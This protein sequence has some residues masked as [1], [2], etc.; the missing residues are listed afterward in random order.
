MKKILTVFSLT[1]LL[2]CG[3]SYGRNNDLPENSDEAA[4]D[5]LLLHVFFATPKYLK[6]QEQ[7]LKVAEGNSSFLHASPA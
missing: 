3:C 2:L 6:M 4:K 7:F 5:I 1:V